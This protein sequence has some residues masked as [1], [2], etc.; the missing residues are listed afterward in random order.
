MP[1]DLSVPALA[2]L[3]VLAV[4]LPLAGLVVGFAVGRCAG[5]RRAVF[6]LD[7][8]PPVL[9]TTLLPG[10][11]RP[12]D[13]HDPYWTTIGGACMAC[14]AERAAAERD[15]ARGELE[16]CRRALDALAGDPR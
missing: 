5:Y 3:A 13:R 11:T 9:N 12:C 1:S 14:R 16:A 6:D 2:A 15:A 7:S 8:T 10:Y 4:F